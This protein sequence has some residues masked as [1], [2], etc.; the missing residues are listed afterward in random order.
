MATKVEE[1]LERLRTIFP[2]MLTA[3]EAAPSN[4]RATVFVG[5]KFPEGSGKTLVEF[6]ASE[7][8][9]DLETVLK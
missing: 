9:A 8:M 7:F 1:A 4:A 5:Y 2:I 3:M 6:D